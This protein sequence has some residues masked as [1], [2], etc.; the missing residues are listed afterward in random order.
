MRRYS[1]IT[2]AR[3]RVA[4]RVQFAQPIISLVCR[5]CFGTRGRRQ[6]GQGEIKGDTMTIKALTLDTGGTILDWHGGI[7]RAFAAADARER[8]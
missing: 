8:L 4:A 6:P 1:D 7:S 2:A 5:S 3:Q